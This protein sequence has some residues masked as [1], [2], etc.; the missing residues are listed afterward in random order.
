MREAFLSL[1]DK[2]LTLASE[3]EWYSGSTVLV[4]L[5]RGRCVRK[6]AKRRTPAA[7]RPTPTSVSASPVQEP[8]I[9]I[10]NWFSSRACLSLHC[11]FSV[12]DG[13]REP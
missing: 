1:D 8:P 10:Y 4:A 11:W 12:F 9:Y 13:C 7:V 6:D 3:R 5:M 2:F